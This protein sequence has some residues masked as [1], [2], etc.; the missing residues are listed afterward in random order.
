MTLAA[1]ARKLGKT[2]Q[3]KAAWLATA[4]SCTGGWVAQAVTSVA[5]SSNWFE[6]GYVTYR[7]EEHTSELQSH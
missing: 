3:A 4:E 6:R 5:G 7:S 1:L 2:L